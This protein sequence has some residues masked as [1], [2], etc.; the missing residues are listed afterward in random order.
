[1]ALPSSESATS[2]APASLMSAHT[3]AAPA[4]VSAVA[5][6]SPMPP[7]AAPVTIATLPSSEKSTIT[8]C[9]P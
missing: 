9:L 4:S 6:A 1:M 8:V 3:T 5:Y 7:A 2:L